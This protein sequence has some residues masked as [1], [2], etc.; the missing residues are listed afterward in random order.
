MPVLCAL[1]LAPFGAAPQ[2]DP[3]S[4]ALPRGADRTETVTARL[5]GRWRLDGASPPLV[6]EFGADGRYRVTGPGG[7][8]EGFW[9]LEGADRIATWRDPSRP[10]RVNRFTFSGGRLV[11]IDARG[12]FH[13]HTRVEE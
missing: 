3:A 6:I 12:R 1:L 10:P 5:V 2:G 9:R 13:K 8:G 7:P 11:I 4:G